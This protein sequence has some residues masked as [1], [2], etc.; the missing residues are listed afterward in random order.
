MPTVSGVRQGCRGYPRR[1]ARHRFQCKPVR[2]GDIP[3]QDGWP[4][5]HRRASP[6]RGPIEAIGLPGIPPT[7]TM[8]RFSRI[9]A[10]IKIRAFRSDRGSARVC[11]RRVPTYPP[12]LWMNLEGG[13]FRSA[14]VTPT[15]YSSFRAF[16]RPFFHC[17]GNNA[18]QKTRK[19]AASRGC[20]RQSCG[21]ERGTRASVAFRMELHTSSP[22]QV[23]PATPRA[24]SLSPP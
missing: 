3:C 7:A 14:A 18:A 21:S 2:G 13:G 20:F 11:A 4:D 15:G 10:L 12:F 8:A 17:T 6:G 19:R 1:R 9:H 22:A 24:R 5:P 16:S 23:E